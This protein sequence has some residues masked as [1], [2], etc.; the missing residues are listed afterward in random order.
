[1]QRISWYVNGPFRTLEQ[2]RNGVVPQYDHAEFTKPTPE[3]LREHYED[4]AYIERMM[5]PQ[6][7]WVDE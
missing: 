3:E 7:G 2:A 1:M 6:S 5:E 4:K